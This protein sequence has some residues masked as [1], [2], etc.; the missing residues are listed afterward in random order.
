[1]S[2]DADAL[3]ADVF[4]TLAIGVDLGRLASIPQGTTVAV[5]CR[6][7]TSW[8][9]YAAKLLAVGEPIFYAVF[10]PDS[11]TAVFMCGPY[12]ERSVAVEQR[13]CGALGDRP[14]VPIVWI[15]PPLAN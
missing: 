10:H 12:A 13:M 11:G 2:S 15:K 4:A 14:G 8:H 1:V 5:A 3:K 6:P 9:D 7:C